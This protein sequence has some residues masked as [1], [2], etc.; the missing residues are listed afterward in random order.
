[1]IQEGDLILLFKDE[2]H[3]YLQKL[4]KGRIHNDLG[5]IET[6]DIIG[7]EYG[8]VIRTSLGYAFY[9]LKPTIFDKSMMLKRMTQILYPKEIGLVLVK[10]NIFP[11]AICIECG[12]GSGSLTTALST[13]VGSEGK[14]YCY[15]RAPE[16]A[17][18]SRKNLDKFGLG[19][20]VEIKLGEI[21]PDGE[22]DV[23][24]VDFVMIDIGSQWDLVPA[25]Y[26]SLKGGCQMATICPTY[27]Q[28]T[29]TVFT[30]EEIGFINIET[31]EIQVRRILVRR[32]KTRPEQHMPC[33]TGF[34]V[35]GTKINDPKAP[36][37][38][39]PAQKEESIEEKPSEPTA[40]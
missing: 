1:M 6:A 33:H 10:A 14:I 27:D 31:I 26:K 29:K 13:F 8:D 25:A 20:N 16:F 32:G 3:T 2:K 37:M 7:K 24:N 4:Q 40:E 9:I 19:K 36:S 5:F 12:M 30:M 15:E 34:L 22:F 18:N 35:F 23:K 17:N 39:M 11:G 38:E 21:L 28:L